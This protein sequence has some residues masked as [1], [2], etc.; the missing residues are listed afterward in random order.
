MVEMIEGF[1]K[2]LPLVHEEPVWATECDGD[3]E[4]WCVI[5]PPLAWR[6]C[7]RP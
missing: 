5:L 2:C 3:N 1:R 6:P 7:E 4:E